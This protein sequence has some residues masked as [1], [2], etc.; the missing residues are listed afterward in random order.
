MRLCKC[1]G[2]PLPRW[3]TSIQEKV[4]PVSRSQAWVHDNSIKFSSL[5]DTH[6]THIHGSSDPSLSAG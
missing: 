1:R 4:T 2:S 3:V 5:S 6:L